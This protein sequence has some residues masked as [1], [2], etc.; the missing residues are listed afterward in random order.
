M[1]KGARN[2]A[3]LDE[4]LPEGN[5]ALVRV[6]LRRRQAR[7]R[8]ADHHI[9]LHRRF[10]RKA[11]AHVVTTS[12]DGLA[13]HDRIRASEIDLFE[14]ALGRLGGR[15]HPLFGDEPLCGDAQNLT[16]ADIAHIFGTHDVEG[17]GLR[18]HDPALGS[19]LLG[20]A[21]LGCRQLAEHE[22]P[23]AIGI[24]EG[25]ERLLVDEGHG[26]AAPDELHRLADALA[27][28]L[29]AL[30]EVADELRRDL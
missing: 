21:V 24:A 27:Q 19:R 23:D 17:T 9:C 3:V 5:A 10:E 8:H 11:T 16:R 30:G 4:A 1:D 2:V 13:A 6:T 15:R 29:R 18:C 28:M 7:I 14:D 12:V 20:I 26:V 22:R 25:I